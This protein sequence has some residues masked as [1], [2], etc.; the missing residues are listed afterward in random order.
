MLLIYLLIGLAVLAGLFCVIAS[1]QPATFRIERSMTMAAPSAVVFGLVNDFHAWNDWSPWA[2]MDP[3]AQNT[4]SGA[5]A[6]VGA[7]YAWVGNGKVGAGKM[8]IEAS[9]PAEL[10]QIKLEFLKPFKATNRAE[11]TFNPEGSSTKVTWAMSGK[12]TFIGKAIGLVMN[13]D[14]MIGGQFEQGLAAMKRLAEAA[15]QK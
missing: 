6:G 15:A 8:T 11:F 10:I 5:P 7:E 3:S 2:K 9:R 4:L 1:L 12:N 13:C 14:K